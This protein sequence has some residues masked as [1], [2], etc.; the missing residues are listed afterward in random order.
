MQTSFYST[1]A[2]CSSKDCT[3]CIRT[4][5]NCPLEADTTESSEE[6]AA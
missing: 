1:K 6:V 5:G 3:R 2:T 4:H